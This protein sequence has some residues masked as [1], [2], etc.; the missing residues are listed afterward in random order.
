MRESLLTLLRD[1]KTPM[2]AYRQASHQIADLL[3][4]EASNL[5]VQD[6]TVVET[7]LGKAPGKK[8]AQRV[9]LVP[10]LRAGMALLPSFLKLFPDAPVG[11]F[12]IRR[13]EETAD[14]HLYYE[15]IPP[16]QQ[17]DLVFLL[18]PMVA[19]AGSTLLAISHLLQK[20]VA[21]AKIVLVSVIASS[22]GLQK[23]K[24][25]YEYLNLVVAA[26]DTELSDKK[27]I[28]PGLGDFG[29]RYFGT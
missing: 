18:D 3:A 5:V 15:N 26:E 28:V 4:A 24:S 9:V 16:L 8:M 22:T 25:K 29:D 6:P 13:N 20:G 10:I 23:I 19:T 21:P 7:P 17:T 11:F 1:Q 12:G 2:A 27:L 14:P